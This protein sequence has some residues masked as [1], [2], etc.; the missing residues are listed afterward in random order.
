MTERLF[1]VE[2]LNLCALGDDDNIFSGGID[3]IVAA[4]KPVLKEWWALHICFVL[5]SRNC[6]PIR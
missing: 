1:V 2:G 4:F 5:V 3:G 6:G